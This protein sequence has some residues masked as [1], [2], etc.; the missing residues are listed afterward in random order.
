MMS[1]SPNTNIAASLHP[2]RLRRTL[3]SFGFRPIGCGPALSSMA[4]FAPLSNFA[5]LWGLRDRSGVLHIALSRRRSRVPLSEI[6][7]PQERK[8]MSTAAYYEVL[9]RVQRL[10][11]ADQLRLLEELAALVRRQVTPKPRQS[12]LDLQ[13]LGKEIWLG[14]DAQDYVDRERASWNG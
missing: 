7:L 5:H 9:N 11:A 13:G 10:T 14:M 2:N 1:D 3:R 4:L 8:H 12:I 6:H